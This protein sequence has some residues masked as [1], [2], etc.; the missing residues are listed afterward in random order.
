MDFS[1][2]SGLVVAVNFVPEVVEP[3]IHDFWEEL[4]CRLASHQS[5]LIVLSTVPIHR[6]SVNTIAVPYNLPEF[7]GNLASRRGEVGTLTT[8]SVLA[9]KVADWYSCRVAL[10]HAILQYVNNYLDDF[11]ATLKPSAM[12]SWQSANPLSH[13]MEVMAAE[14]GIPYWAGERGWLPNTL[15]FDVCQNNHLSEMKASVVSERL[16]RSFSPSSQ[17]IS[18][19]VERLKAGGQGRYRSKEAQ[20]GETLRARLGIAAEEKVVAYFSH[21]EP[22]LFAGDNAFEALHGIER[23]GYAQA[24]S[25]LQS[26]CERHGIVLLVQDHPLNKGTAHQFQ[27]SGQGRV[28]V[29][30]EN[31]HSVLDAADASIFSNS[32]V[33]AYALAH[34]KPFG[35]L[36]KSFLHCE[37]GPLFLGDFCSSEDFFHA[38]I[39]DDRWSER[40]TLALRELAFLKEHFLLDID[41]SHVQESAETFSRVLSRYRRYGSHDFDA[42]VTAFLSRWG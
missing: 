31:V 40:R 21:S 13:L 8:S 42:A 23:S 4:S 6:P 18:D 37:A 12:L 9:R 11:C 25:D 19:M 28:L 29:L 10:A 38:V 7:A 5:S 17:G 20:S 30:E 16:R 24:I 2:S 1:E 22:L 39:N 41:S 27:P 26:Y 35:L 32:T 36:T 15:M 34:G 33:Q 14:R 3:A